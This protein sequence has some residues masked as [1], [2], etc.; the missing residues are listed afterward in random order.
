MARKVIPSPSGDQ[1]GGREKYPEP[2]PD[3]MFD[4]FELGP[5]REP[6]IGAVII[7]SEAVKQ[8]G[9]PYPGWEKFERYLAYSFAL[10]LRFLAALPYDD[11]R[12]Q[13]LGLFLSSLDFEK[14]R[15]RRKRAQRDL[16]WFHHGLRMN[17]LWDAELQAAWNMKESLQRSGD[18]LERL[19]KSFPNDV[20][21]VISTPKVTTE[22]SLSR[23]YARRHNLMFGTARNALRAYKKVTERNFAPQ[24]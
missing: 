20:V 2:P 18:S 11:A 6:F 8:R 23:L 10:L 4:L 21:D 17:R 22:S 13:L 1:T 12:S 14:K 24:I 9:T 19:R 15:G 16:R 5:I 3:I 7:Y